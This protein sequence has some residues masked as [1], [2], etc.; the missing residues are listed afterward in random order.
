MRGDLGGSDFTL[1]QFGEKALRLAVALISL[2]D[3]LVSIKL[4]GKANNSRLFAPASDSD[5]V[6]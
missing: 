4:H 1:K 3:M 2:F 5:N 6:P